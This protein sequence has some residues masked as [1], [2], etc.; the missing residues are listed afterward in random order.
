MNGLHFTWA[1]LHNFNHLTKVSLITK[2]KFFSSASIFA[3]FEESETHFEDVSSKSAKIIF[4]LIARGYTAW[5]SP[6][7]QAFVVGSNLEPVTV[8][9]GTA[10]FDA[11]TLPFSIRI[12]VWQCYWRKSTIVLKFITVV[13][14]IIVEIVIVI[15]RWSLVE[16]FKMFWCDIQGIPPGTFF[17]TTRAL[18]L[19]LE[20]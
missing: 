10:F 12:Q 15:M 2:Q 11:C 14:T 7:D 6:K 18:Q 16:V 1:V 9:T 19:F 17:Q 8:H 13:L 5:W 3:Y 20:L 4:N